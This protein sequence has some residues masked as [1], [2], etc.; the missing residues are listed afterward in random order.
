MPEGEYPSVYVVDSHAT[1]PQVPP[2]LQKKKRSAGAV[3]TLL[4]LLA[5]SASSSKQT[6]GE[7]IVPPKKPSLVISPSKPVAHLTDGHGTANGDQVLAWSTVAEPLLYKMK[8]KDK[9]L[10]IQ[11]EGYYYVYSKVSFLDNDIFHHSVQVKTKLFAGKSIQLLMSRKY[12]DKYSKNR[13]N[14]YLGGVFHLN[15]DDALFVEV[16]NASKILR[17]RDSENIFGAYMI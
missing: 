6:A 13:S 7:D 14:S 11:R 8:Y 2:R 15:K 9:S 17:H 16:N 1:K 10:I 3:Q 12:S 4:F 5:A